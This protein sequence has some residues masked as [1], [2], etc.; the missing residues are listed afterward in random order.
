MEGLILRDSRFVVAPLKR[1]REGLP[2]D[3]GGMIG[4]AYFAA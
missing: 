1:E 3:E 2:H 4:E